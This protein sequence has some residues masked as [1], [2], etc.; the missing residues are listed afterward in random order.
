MKIVY[1]I[2]SLIKV[3]GTER[4]LV[5]KA[6]Y[7]ADKLGHEVHI[8]I[9]EQRNQ[10]L[11][12]FISPK[13]AVHHLKISSYLKSKI[14]IKGFTFLYMVF[15]LKKVYQDI[16]DKI[17]PDVIAVLELGYED[18]IIPRLKTNALKTREVHSSYKAQK[19]IKLSNKV[20][21]KNYLVMK[22]YDFLLR[23]YDAVVLLT[24]QDLY[25]RKSIKNKYAIPN[26]VSVDYDVNAVSDTKKVISVGR[27]DVFKNFADQI[28][29]WSKIVVKH[30][31]WTLHIYGEG[32]ER[33]ALQ[34]LINELNLN[35]KVVL[36]GSS[37]K[38][39]ERYN[40]SSFF[41]FTS[42]AEGFGMVLIEAMQMG[43]PVVAYDCPCGPNEII[44]DGKNGFLI[45]INDRK[46]FELKTLFLIENS[47][48]R[49]QMAAHAK[50][51]SKRYYPAVLVPKWIEL[52]QNLI[53]KK[54]SVFN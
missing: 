3:G 41:I 25:D 23:K 20:N 18:F 35:E 15:L 51:Y 16:I 14:I 48:Q 52:Y 6:N 45:A 54:K 44:E 46:E 30:P 24:V 9:A 31:D 19:I 34:N 33:I 50:E 13:V 43:L 47:D 12:F 8:I 37:D 40:E 21:I 39:Y 5:N 42:L 17:N 1:C 49:K 53:N 11:C 4:V 7:L 2:G 36:E 10:P 26:C 38:I 28:I 32:R 22:C 27:L 29:V